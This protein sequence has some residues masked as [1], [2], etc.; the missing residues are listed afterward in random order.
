MA[1]SAIGAII[2]ELNA[3]PNVE[4][5]DTIKP[6]TGAVIGRI[7]GTLAK[8]PCAVVVWITLSTAALWQ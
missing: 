4:L 2:G 3:A 7:M 5:K 8:F 6:A 1:G